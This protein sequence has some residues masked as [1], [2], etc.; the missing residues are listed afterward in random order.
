MQVRIN[1]VEYYQPTYDVQQNTTISELKQMIEDHVGIP[2][3]NFV[4]KFNGQTLENGMT[5]GY[6]KIHEGSLLDIEGTLLPTLHPRFVPR[7]R[8]TNFLSQLDA[9][10]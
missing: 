1:L 7:C 8:M 4:L 6:Y 2:T 10:C 9:I 5:L 3:D